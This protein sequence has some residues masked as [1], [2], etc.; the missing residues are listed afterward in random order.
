MTSSAPYSRTI[1]ALAAAAHDC[2]DSRAEQMRE[3]NASQA[4]P[5]GGSRHEDRFTSLQPCPLDQGI[6]SRKIGVH[7]C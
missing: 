7:D 5:A 4:N 3:L 1:A 6:P 2:N